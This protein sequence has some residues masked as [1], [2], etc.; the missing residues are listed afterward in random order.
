[1]QFF[2]ESMAKVL[3]KLPQKMIDD[4]MLA[5]ERSYNEVK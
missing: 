4:N 2:K 1:M 5:I 3:K